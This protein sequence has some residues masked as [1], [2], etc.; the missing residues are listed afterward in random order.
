MVP[1]LSSWAIVTAGDPEF[2]SLM[3]LSTA[4][5]RDLYLASRDCCLA[6]GSEGE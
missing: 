6:G 4:S 2:K 3:K 5:L 1:E